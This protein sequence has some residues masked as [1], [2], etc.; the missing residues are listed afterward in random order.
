[1]AIDGIYISRYFTDEDCLVLGNFEKGLHDRGCRLY[2][3]NL[4]GTIMHSAFD[5]ADLELIGIAYSVLR[6]FMMSGSYDLAKHFFLCLWRFI[7][8]D[9]Q[10][11]IPFTLSIEGIPTVSGSENINCKI[12][13]S[14]PDDLREKALE[15][16]FALASQI[17]SHQLQLL[18]RSRYYDA[19]NAHLFTYASPVLGF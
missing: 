2:V 7:T 6:A 19:L 9:R 4:S 17:E 14:L 18:E 12:S 1:M 16:T 3:R 15:K 5:F 8:K 11:D 10:S 13:G